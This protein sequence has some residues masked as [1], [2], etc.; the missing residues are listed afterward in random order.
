MIFLDKIHKIKEIIIVEGLHDKIRLG[1]LID[2][3]IITTDGFQ[4]YKNKEKIALIKRLG[5]VCGVIVLTD[6][7]SAGSRIR[8]FLK[9]TL[10]LQNIKQVYTPQIKGKE[11]RKDKA[12]KEGFLGVE[13]IDCDILLD[14]ILQTAS[15]DIDNSPKITKQDFMEFGLS[16]HTNSSA[17]RRELCK[18]IGLPPR[19]SSTALV[20][21]VNSLYTPNEFKKIL[22]KSSLNQ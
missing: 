7:D 5:E 3:V 8:G 9:N 1:R 10:K 20:D 19:I 4:I 18:S 17:L 14:L 6:S 16:G 13:G 12:S 15:I 2:T 22:Q 21:A 11:H